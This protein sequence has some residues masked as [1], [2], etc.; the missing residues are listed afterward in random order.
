MTTLEQP[1]NTI[2]LPRSYRVGRIIAHK[3]KYVQLVSR[4]KE[5]DAFPGGRGVCRFTTKEIDCE[6]VFSVME[7]WKLE[8]QLPKVPNHEILENFTI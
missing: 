8:N 6:N 5:M 3:G 4:E 7:L 1:A 2:M